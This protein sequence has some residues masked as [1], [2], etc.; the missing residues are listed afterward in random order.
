MHEVLIVL[1]EIYRYKFKNFLIKNFLHPE[2]AFFSIEFKGFDPKTGE[3]EEMI[4][5]PGMIKQYENNAKRYVRISLE[6]LKAYSKVEN[7]N[8]GSEQSETVKKLIAKTI[9]FLKDKKEKDAVVS[10]KKVF[11]QIANE[12]TKLF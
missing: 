7:R 6:S 8:T 9:T 1:S 11:E 12:M 3:F 4:K 10:L 5:K 2:Y